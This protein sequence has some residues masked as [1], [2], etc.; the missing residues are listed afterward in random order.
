M[1]HQQTY[2]DAASPSSSETNLRPTMRHPHSSFHNP[3]FIFLT[4]VIALSVLLPGQL[5]AAENDSIG[6]ALLKS[7]Y[8]SVLLHRQSVNGLSVS[9]KVNGRPTRLAICTGAPI[10]TID[11]ASAQKF[12]VREEKSDLSISGAFGL[13]N[14]R[15]GISRRNTIE[16]ANIVQPDVAFGVYNEPNL[17]AD[18]KGGIAGVFGAPQLSRLAAIIDCGTARMYLRPGGADRFASGR[19][20]ALLA[21]RGFTRIPMQVNSRRHFEVACRLNQRNSV[22]TIETCATLTS[23]THRTAAAAGITSINAALRAQ[24]AGGSTSPVKTGQVREFSIGGVPII[25][26]DISVTNSDFNIFGLDYLARY[27][28]VIDLGGRSLYLRPRTSSRKP[29]Q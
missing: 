6:N 5:S 29:A 13:L 7:G 22:I 28:A 14:Q 16:L 26:S 12:G 9:V 11:R 15:L 18:S 20:G 19:L 4:A 1:P 21:G 25:G 23:I 24:A 2:R 27:S 8:R 3:P 10:S 17:A